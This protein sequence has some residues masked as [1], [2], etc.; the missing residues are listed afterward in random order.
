[1]ACKRKLAKIAIFSL[2]AVILC[3]KTVFA[4]TTLSQ[5][6]LGFNVFPF[7]FTFTNLV[8]RGTTSAFAASWL[9][10]QS[11]AGQNTGVNCT[12]IGSSNADC[13]LKPTIQGAGAGGCSVQ[14]P[15]YNLAPI[16]TS[17][18]FAALNNVSC[19]VYYVPNM[20]VNSTYSISFSPLAFNATA[21]LGSL[22]VGRSVPLRVNIQNN[23]LMTDQYTVNFTSTSLYIQFSNPNTQT[24]N[25]QGNPTNES[26]YVQTD[27]TAL[28]SMGTGTQ[29]NIQV[30]ST[31]NPAIGQQI[32]IQ[33]TAGLASLPDFTFLGIMQILILAALILL[34][35]K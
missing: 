34:A 9:V 3:S 29:I 20:L 1:M 31:V 12:F 27:V 35:K 17:P 24:D 8:G 18:N 10:Q 6:T 15:P 16:P 5:A 28:A 32:S 21:A 11:E 22:T 19:L 2:I 7:I 30:N 26:G 13:L 33:L 25:L 4:Q 14:Y 23:G